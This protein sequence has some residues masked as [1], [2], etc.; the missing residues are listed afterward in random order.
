MTAIPVFEQQIMQAGMDII[1]INVPADPLM[2][3]ELYLD[4]NAPFEEKFR[5]SDSTWSLATEHELTS[6]IAWWK[7]MVDTGKAAKALETAEAVRALI[8][9]STSIT[10]HKKK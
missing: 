3:K 8:G 6:G 1:D 4:I 5:N 2:S 7:R 9:Q 10:S